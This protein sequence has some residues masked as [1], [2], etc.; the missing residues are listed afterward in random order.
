MGSKIREK[1]SDVEEADNRV[2]LRHIN[3]AINCGLKT[4]DSDIVVI[5]QGLYLRGSS[6][7]LMQRLNFG[8]S[9]T[10]VETKDLLT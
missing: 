9:S 3:D 5:L 7:N 1:W 8:L 10:L 4:V 2:L 6:L